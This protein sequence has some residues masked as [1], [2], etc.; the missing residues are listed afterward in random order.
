MLRDMSGESNSLMARML[1]ELYAAA[2]DDGR[3]LN[4][5]RL[6]SKVVQSRGH[7]LACV[8]GNS[9]R[10][11]DL[12]FVRSC[13]DGERRDVL[14]RAYFRDAWMIDESV[15]RIRHLRHGELTP[16]C[17]LYTEAE[18]ESSPVYNEVRAKAATQNG[19]VVR[20]AGPAESHMVWNLADSLVPGGW[21]SAQ[22]DT[23][24]RVLPHVQ[25]FALTR[26]AVGDATAL[27]NSASGLLNNGGCG[28]IQ[29][30]G[31]G[32][33]VVVNDVARELL[34]KADRLCDQ[35]GFL[36]ARVRAD[37]TQL[38]QLVARALP[39]PGGQPAAGM[40]TL[41][42]WP[43][44]TR[45]VVEI[46]PT[47]DLR[48]DF[49]PQQVAVI[50]RVVD[51]GLRLEI[52]PGVPAAALGLTRAESKIAIMLAAGHNVKGIAALTSRSE[53]TIRWHLHRIYRKLRI[54]RQPE[55]VQRVV[56]LGYLL[57]PRIQ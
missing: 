22:L 12:L 3:W 52:D 18:R 56:A 7:A 9:Q 23:I 25:Q 43:A 41:G 42:S 37:D 31:S 32:R 34:R 14:E 8:R 45:L 20:L 17:D 6:I 1:R 30:D 15:P 47:G 57:G 54:N 53:S 11:A 36:K 48:W 10:D 33:I 4:A 27:G 5:A 28:V 21:S 39:R 51:P 19:L 16:V 29:L 13:F 40:T 46:S 35:D 26:Q 44:K 55:L 49:R 50:V 38:Q 2:Y 24:T